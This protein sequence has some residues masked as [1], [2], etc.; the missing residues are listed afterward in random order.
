[1]LRYVH[2]LASVVGTAAAAL[3]SGGCLLLH[4]TH[5]AL[6][7][8]DPA[9]LRWREDY[10]DPV[11]LVARRPD[12]SRTVRLW[13]LGEVVTEVAAAGLVVRRLEEFRSPAAV[14]RHDPRVPGEF[15]L[16]ALKP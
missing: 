15:A 11:L 5:P 12:E 4:D 3:R 8:L 10:F 2:D 14:R 6:E 13:R 1:V 9:S 16:L 7:C